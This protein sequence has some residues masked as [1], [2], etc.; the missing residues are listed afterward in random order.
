[1]ESN[2]LHDNMQIYRLCPRSLQSFMTFHAVVDC[3]YFWVLL[4]NKCCSIFPN[5]TLRTLDI[6]WWICDITLW[7]KQ[8]KCWVLRQSSTLILCS[9]QGAQAVFTRLILVK[10]IPQKLRA[11]QGSFFKQYISFIKILFGY[12]TFALQITESLSL[13]FNCLCV[14]RQIY[15][16]LCSYLQVLQCF[17]TLTVHKYMDRKQL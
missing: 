15:Q 1:M 13:K 8:G 10:F 17:H 7:V 4:L 9:L 6:G 5:L 2:F 3:L 11:D 16:L 12:Q 14:K